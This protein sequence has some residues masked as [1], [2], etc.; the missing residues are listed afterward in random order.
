MQF[1]EWCQTYCVSNTRV[2]LRNRNFC[3]QR[4]RA[5]L[6]QASRVLFFEAKKEKS[7][8][9]LLGAQRH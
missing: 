2:R 5:R 9:K 7:L 1:L 6:V 8:S 4:V 3:C